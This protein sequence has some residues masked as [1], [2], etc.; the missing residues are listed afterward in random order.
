MSA[1]ARQD[2]E[3]QQEVRMRSANIIAGI[4]IGA[5]FLSAFS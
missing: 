2:A 3:L 5:V 1:R 4:A